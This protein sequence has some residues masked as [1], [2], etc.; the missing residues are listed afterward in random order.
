MV[1]QAEN[2]FLVPRIM[3]TALRLRAA[4]I[5]TVLAVGAALGGPLGAVLAAPLTA[6]LREWVVYIRVRMGGPEPSENSSA[7]RPRPEPRRK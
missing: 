1:Q 4:V 3:G 6:L 7:P 5:M 2:S